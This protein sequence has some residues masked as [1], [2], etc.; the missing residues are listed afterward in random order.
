MAKSNN[1]SDTRTNFAKWHSDWNGKT[2]TISSNKKKTKFT[3]VNISRLKLS[4]RIIQFEMRIHENERKRIK[5][6]K[7]TREHE[8][9]CAQIMP[10]HK[11]KCIVKF[12]NSSHSNTHNGLHT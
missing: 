5:T 1:F 11:S 7:T 10:H 2:G 12:Q 9:A 8:S 3:F 6:N 4:Y